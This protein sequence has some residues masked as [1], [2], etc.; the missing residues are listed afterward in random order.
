M[1]WIKIETYGKLKPGIDPEFPLAGLDLEL[2]QK[3]IAVLFDLEM[4]DNVIITRVS[5]GN[6]EALDRSHKVD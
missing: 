3:A 1:T 6:S 2:T 4:V 5:E